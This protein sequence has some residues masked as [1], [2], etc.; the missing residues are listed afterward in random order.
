MILNAEI[1]TATYLILQIVG[2][3]SAVHALF[4]VRTAQGATAWIVG[5]LSF[6]LVA[7]PAY[8]VFGCRRFES[9]RRAM[10]LKLARHAGLMERVVEGWRPF[11][12]ERPDLQPAAAGALAELAGF[13]FLAGNRLRLLIDGE[14]TFGE[15]LREIA[16]ARES[17]Y[18]Q[19][20]IVRDDGL[21]NRLLE[22]MA[23]RAEAGVKVCFLYDSFGGREITPKVA[24][25][26][27]RR[28]I[29]MRE[30]CSRA[31]G[32]DRWR[33]NFRNHRKSVIVDGRTG[34][35]GGHNVGDEYLGLNP[36]YGRWRDTH[37]R[38]EGPAVQQLQKVFAAD[39]FYMTDEILP[40]PWDPVP[41]AVAAGTAAADQRALVLASG[42]SDG[43]ERCTLFF[44]HVIG[45]ARRRIWIASPYFVP[46]EAV[47]QALQLAAVRGVEVRILI[48]QEP[49]KR[50]VW[51]AS[52]QMLLELEHPRIHIHRFTGG[53][54]HHKAL[55][56]DDDFAAVGTANFDNR[57]FRLN[58]ELTLA[59]ADRTFAGEVAAMFERDFAESRECSAQGYSGLSRLDKIGVR[60]ARLLAPIL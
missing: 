38:V 18:V 42:P 44:L 29:D 27:R 22:A 45:M 51:L 39:W 52:F 41:P 37:V 25:P 32:R 57:S 36:K 34:F 40:G 54:L 3:S 26:W 4:T 48:P 23:R 43:F 28:G 47:I 14:E 49:D 17:V 5:L 50:L 31:S 20:Y 30:F 11:T 2:I 58:F 7:V 59:V 60:V 24:D 15:I 1:V 53:F 16:T 33:I 46:D 6:P 56:V 55:V 9:H 8:F 13:E 19:F 21:G 12:V 35:V 10:E